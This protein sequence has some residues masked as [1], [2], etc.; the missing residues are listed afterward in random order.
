[1]DTHTSSSCHR[2]HPA[3]PLDALPNALLPFA[4]PGTRLAGPGCKAFHALRH[5]SWRTGTRAT[6]ADLAKVYD[7]GSLL[8]AAPSAR[9]DLA[10]EGEGALLYPWPLYMDG[11][12]PAPVADPRLEAYW[13]AY[14]AAERDGLA[15]CPWW[16]DR[17]D[18]L[19]PGIND[20]ILAKGVMD[21]AAAGLL[22][23]GITPGRLCLRL[24]GAAWHAPYPDSGEAPRYKPAR[25]SFTHQGVH[26]SDPLT[27]P[28]L[29][30][31]RFVETALDTRFLSRAPLLRGQRWVFRAEEGW[32][33]EQAIVFSLEA[34]VHASAASGISA[35][36]SMAWA[37]KAAAL[38]EDA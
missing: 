33:Q 31:L 8:L 28:G 21:I 32:L 38:M 14:G 18:P 9:G 29:V 27:D 26:T 3:R 10:T 22:A 25:F 36:A 5:G 17:I 34:W 11:P 4:P 19:P 13:E 23:R 30:W 2:P 35:H 7:D 16:Q 20:Q 37:A 6:G 24:L 12:V 1:M 15:P